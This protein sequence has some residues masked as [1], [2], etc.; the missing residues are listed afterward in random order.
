MSG[1]NPYAVALGRMAAGKPK[2]FSA[3]TIEQLRQRL[4]GARAKRAEMIM[5]RNATSDLSRR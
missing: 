2:R 5:A 3:A 4:V 1:K